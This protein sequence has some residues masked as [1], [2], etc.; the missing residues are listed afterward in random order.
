[1]GRSK[2]SLNNSA[3]KSPKPGTTPESKIKSPMNGKTTP[4]RPGSKRPVPVGSEESES[5]VETVMPD[6]RIA[7]LKASNKKLKLVDDRSLDP[8]EDDVESDEEEDDEDVDVDEDDDEEDDSDD[9]DDDE[10]EDDDEDDDDEEEDDEDDEDSE[11][12]EEDDETTQIAVGAK[13]AGSKNA[14]QKLTPQQKGGK[15]TPSVPAAPPKKAATETKVESGLSG[16]VIIVNGPDNLDSLR[17]FLSKITTVTDIRKM[18]PAPVLA[19]VANLNI[20]KSRLQSE[21]LTF[22]GKPLEIIPVNQSGDARITDSLYISGIPKSTTIDQ[23]RDHLPE[24][25]HPVDF[26]LITRN[27]HFNNAVLAFPSVEAAIKACEV[28]RSLK[29]GDRSMRVSFTDHV[30]QKSFDLSPTIVIP[31]FTAHPDR[32]RQLFPTCIDVTHDR[33]R[34]K[35]FVKFPS[36][37]VRRAAISEPKFLNG[38]KLSLGLLGGPELKTA[39]I[40][41]VPATVPDS[42]I[43][44][45]FAGVVSLS[46]SARSPKDLCPAV[47]VEFK[48]AAD[49]SKAISSHVTLKG[50][51]LVMF[52]KAVFVDDA[53]QKKVENVNSA[54]K[55]EPPAKKTKAAEET[56]EEDKLKLKVNKALKAKETS[57][58]D[59]EEVEED[60]DDDDEGDEEDSE[61][62][63]EDE[64]E[65]EEDD[66]DDD[67]DD[68]DEDEEDDDDDDDD[69]SEEDTHMASPNDQK[70]KKP[71]NT[72]HKKP[73]GEVQKMNN[74]PGGG[75]NFRG[76]HKFGG[77]LKNNSQRG[78][79]DQSFRGHGGQ[80]PRGR[81][82]QSF[83]GHGGQSPRGR[84]GNRGGWPKQGSHNKNK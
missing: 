70:N 1:M 5:D 61:E 54:R 68:E 52:P 63:E 41:R 29:L 2:Q 28:L 82:G 34:K 80:S 17:E 75:A 4:M 79:G 10:E 48:T 58:A 65:D 27:P 26:K 16:S 20:L 49:C 19:T 55:S 64:E 30:A 53:S 36:L 6:D 12:G 76:S 38:K 32:L 81:G 78:R 66:D 62:E 8:E 69:E 35:A 23:L 43:E 3:V 14:P 9:D 77:N 50:Q 24:N 83:R 56:S 67:D 74:R 15:L 72:P 31:Y 18:E 40:L 22:Q 44:S 37:E 71:Q 25:C 47:T 57:D 60:E 39:L 45:L 11:E 21:K 33:E 51:R 59:E 7:S 84:G 46:R 42:E 73:F 13:S